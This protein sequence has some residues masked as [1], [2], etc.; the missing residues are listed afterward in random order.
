MTLML[1]WCKVEIIMVSW[2]GAA[3][4]DIVSYDK[5]YGSE[6]ASGIGPLHT[7]GAPNIQI[8]RSNRSAHVSLLLTH[9]GSTVRV[10][11]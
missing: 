10:G 4:A 5:S 11:R 7:S 6:G 2:K 8:Q 9:L 3:T 1:S